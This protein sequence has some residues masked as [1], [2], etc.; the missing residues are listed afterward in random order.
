MI[1][2]ID[3]LGFRWPLSTFRRHSFGKRKL[4]LLLIRF[5]LS[6]SLIQY[7][8]LY[9]F[10]LNSF[11]LKMPYIIVCF[12]W[13]KSWHRVVDMQHQ[14]SQTTNGNKYVS[15]EYKSGADN[16]RNASSSEHDSQWVI[17]ELGFLLALRSIIWKSYAQAFLNYMDVS[18]KWGF[19]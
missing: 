6:Y 1:L 11:P 17:S 15:F 4:N 12:S 19:C 13:L 9:H 10:F 2:S 5:V 18:L 8:L 3:I 7:L 16:G 14:E